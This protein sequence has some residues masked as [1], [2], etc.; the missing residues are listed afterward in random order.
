[1]NQIQHYDKTLINISPKEWPAFLKEHAYLP[2]NSMNIPLAE[3]FTETA[4]LMD[5][6]R[7]IGIITKH[8]KIQGRSS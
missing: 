5:F 1:M 4:T 8:L 7:Y 2:D 6:K 3:A